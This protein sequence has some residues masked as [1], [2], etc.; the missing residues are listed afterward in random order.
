MCDTMIAEKRF[1]SKEI[2]M[3]LY[4]FTVKDAQGLD[5]SLSDY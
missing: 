4:D 1:T 3:K 2:K 5:V